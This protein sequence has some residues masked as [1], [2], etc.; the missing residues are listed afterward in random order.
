MESRL[1]KYFEYLKTAHSLNV[2]FP[3]NNMGQSWQWRDHNN[4]GVD[5]VLHHLKIAMLAEN[6]MIHSLGKLDK[7]DKIESNIEDLKKNQK[8]L[9]MTLRKHPYCLKPYREKSADI[10]NIDIASIIADLQYHLGVI[11]IPGTN[12]QLFSFKENKVIDQNRINNYTYDEFKKFV[13]KD[14][15]DFA[16]IVI[17]R[18]EGVKSSICQLAVHKDVL[19]EEKKRCVHLLAKSEALS[20]LRKYANHLS[21]YE[22]SQMEAMFFSQQK[23][24]KKQTRQLRKENKILQENISQL[25]EQIGKLQTQFNFFQLEMSKNTRVNKAVVSQNNTSGKVRR[26]SV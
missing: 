4:Y 2:N 12:E 10:C 20:P 16:M 19:D 5:S 3:D 8:K 26:I 15:E 11:P 9:K 6:D 14:N 22:L 13:A 17:S 7:L 1:D 21:M 23:L 24:Q 25:Q 18:N